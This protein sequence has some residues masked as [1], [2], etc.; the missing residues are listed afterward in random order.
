MFKITGVSKNE[1]TVV[2]FAETEIEA[3]HIC[4]Y[5]NAKSMLA[6]TGISYVYETTDTLELEIPDF[7]FVDAVIWYDENDQLCIEISESSERVL[8]FEKDEENLEWH[9]NGLKIQLTKFRKQSYV[10]NE[11]FKALCKHL[12]G[13]DVE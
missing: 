6:E 5:F 3:K 8:T 1:V 13:V 7:M 4:A 10:E 9:V 2:G 12:K 11:V